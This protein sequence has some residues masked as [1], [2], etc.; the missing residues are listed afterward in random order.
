MQRGLQMDRQLVG[1]SVSDIVAGMLGYAAITTALYAREKTGKGTTVDVAMLDATMSL[2]S[3][4]LMT[5]LGLNQ[6][7]HRIGN[8]H[9]YMYPFDTFACQ[10]QP[11]AICCGNDHLWSLLVNA[12]NHPEW[13][14]DVQMKTNDLRVANWQLV[15]AHLESVLQTKPAAVWEQLLT[16]AGVPNGVV[17]NIDDTRRLPQVVARG[18]VKTLPDGNKVMGNPLK[19]GTWNSYGLQTDAPKYNENE[20]QIRTEFKE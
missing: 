20:N 15:K 17:M 8:R 12:L 11:L 14:D 19:Y 9:P 5:S 1:T 2:M 6:V 13:Q 3:Q 10:D 18:M 16:S 4:D 7:P